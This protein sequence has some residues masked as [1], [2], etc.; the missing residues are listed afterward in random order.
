MENQLKHDATNHY[1]N[2]SSEE[3]M[4]NISLAIYAGMLVCS[5]AFAQVSVD[6][7]N[8]N[9]R[10][11]S[12]KGGT[13]IINSGVIEPDADIEGVTIINNK[14]FIDGEEVPKGK[15]TFVSKKTKKRY[16]ISWGKD[17]NIAVAEK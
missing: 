11:Q 17:G 7:S 13:V 12:G 3:K 10:V 8:G 14:V 6:T 1:V 15:N 2:Q 16:S 5:T 9:V 4:K